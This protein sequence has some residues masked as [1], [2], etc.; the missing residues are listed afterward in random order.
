M[1]LKRHFVA[2]GILNAE[3]DEYL[4]KE[5]AA[6]GYQ[7]VKM[8]KT[9]LGTRITVFAARPGLVIGKRGASVK[10]LTIALEEIFGIDNPS[11]DVEEINPDFNA[12]IMAER[13]ATALVKGQHYRRATYGIIRRVMRAGA[14]GIE[15]A[16]SGKITSQRARNQRFREG[17]VS[18]CG[19]PALEGVSRGV[20]HCYMKPGVL[21]VRVKIMPGNYLM[22]DSV[23]IL[24]KTPPP[25]TEPGPAEE[26]VTLTEKIDEGKEEGLFTDEEGE[27]KIESPGDEDKNE[28]AEKTA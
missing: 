13:L 21:G 19:T 12:Q 26:S 16:V 27:D 4:G 22:P 20:A 10:K 1:P 18:K 6:A 17:I 2:K 7:G 28:V 15:I 25:A 3:I 14:R 11:I 9:P 23:T 5:L 8:Q 24:E